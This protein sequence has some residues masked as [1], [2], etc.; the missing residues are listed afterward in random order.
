MATVFW[1]KRKQLSE[2]VT[3]GLNNR[4]NL[5]LKDSLLPNVT[6]RFLSDS[7]ET[8]QDLAWV[9]QQSEEIGLVCAQTPQF[10]SY[11]NWV[12]SDCSASRTCICYAGAELYWWDCNN[13][14]EQGRLLWDLIYYSWTL[15]LCLHFTPLPNPFE[16]HSYSISSSLSL[17]L[18]YNIP[19][20]FLDCHSTQ[21]FG[22]QYLHF[23]H[24]RGAF[25][26]I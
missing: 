3:T 11:P 6:P 23:I 14:V 2:M 18:P 19:K 15:G 24:L 4:G 10:C 20:I 7:T 25:V 16:Q 26:C 21:Q 1:Q 5:C 22:A 9:G 8:E 17:R 12:S 13:F